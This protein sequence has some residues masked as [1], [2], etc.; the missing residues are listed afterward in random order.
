M[1][2]VLSDQELRLFQTLIYDQAGIYMNDNKRALISGRLFKRLRHHGLNSFRDYY[3]LAT[4]PGSPELQLLVD[5]LTT[6]ETY[7][8]LEPSHFEYLKTVVA[9]W[10]ASQSLRVW[11]AAC[12]SG[13]EPYSIA[14]V[15][16][17]ARVPRRELLASDINQ[18]ILDRAAR[19][20]YPLRAAE[21]IPRPYL[22]KYCWKGKGD[23][24]GFFRMGQELRRGLTFARVNLDRPFPELGRFHMI[25]LRN[26][27]IYFNNETRRA[28]VDRI[29][30]ALEPEG[31]FFIGH[32]ETLHRITDRMR[33]V[34]PAV[35][36][37]IG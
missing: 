17:E 36:R 19:G 10:P 18:T 15:L 29:A 7:F 21:K 28:I 13:E 16:A 9:D 32:S 26:A 23:N 30:D 5:L 35:Y 14:M 22:L 24:A 1:N 2:P 11:S 25:W 4:E 33:V 6:N 34:Q 27:M 8:F 31:Y 20:V 37:K 3:R 12:S